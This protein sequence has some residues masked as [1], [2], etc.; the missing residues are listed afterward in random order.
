[1]KM[2]TK[3]NDKRKL[4]WSA[5]IVIGLLCSCTLLGAVLAIRHIH[6]YF[7][8]TLKNSERLLARGKPREAKALLDKMR[9]RGIKRNDASA[10]LLRGRVLYSVLL[11]QLREERW[12]SY[13]VNPEN[14]IDHPLAAEAERYFLDAMAISPD[15]PEIRLVLGN[16]YREQG[17]FS[18][19]ESIL[20]SALEIDGSNAEIYLA[21]GLLYAE[22]NRPNGARKALSMAWELDKNNPQIAKNIA[23]F[24]R[25]YADAPE[26]SIV[27]FKRYLDSNP[28]RDADVNLVRAELRNLMERYP[29]FVR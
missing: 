13:G 9:E 8:P 12:G 24:Y 1:M 21:L 2:M 5:I 29:E 22:A 14:W 11:E 4:S 3:T 10:L 20:R 19:A 16:L 25:F 18:D 17:R 23:F 28:R 15:D 7:S 27:W 26:S 6:M